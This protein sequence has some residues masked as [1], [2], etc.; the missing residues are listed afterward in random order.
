MPQP[1]DSDHEEQQEGHPRCRGMVEFN[2]RHVGRGVVERLVVV[3]GVIFPDV[4]VDPEL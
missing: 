1:H 4:G 2:Q 3:E